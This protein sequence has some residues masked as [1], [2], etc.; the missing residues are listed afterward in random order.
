MLTKIDLY[1]EV[2]AIEPNSKVFFPLAK[3]L[4]GLDQPEEAV[5]VLKKG[6]AFHP[7]HLE[8]KFLL[9]ELLTRLER[10]DEAEEA[11]AGVGEMLAEYPSVWSL[12]AEKAV[13]AAKDPSLAL[14]FLAHYFRDG[15]L[16][17]ASVLEHGL[18]TLSPGAAPEPKTTPHSTDIADIA[19]VAEAG[20]ETEHASL[21]EIALEDYPLG[22]DEPE[23]L[24]HD[25]PA[26]EAYLEEPPLDDAGY[27]LE[28]ELAALE[29]ADSADAADLDDDADDA[30][31]VLRGADEVRSLAGILDDGPEEETAPDVDETPEVSAAQDLKEEEGGEGEEGGAD[32]AKA[33]SPTRAPETAS[34]QLPDM[35]V[36]TMTMAAMLAQQG[37]SKAA[38]AIYED[39]L[40]SAGSDEERRRIEKR[41]EELRNGSEVAAPSSQPAQK[42]KTGSKSKARLSGFL[43]ALAGRL[44]V[45]AR[46]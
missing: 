34:I 5:D 22:E 21:D 18:N 12:W 28:D 14:R 19:E 29:A 43:E 30:D 31:V 15:S 32:G 35:G 10:S 8:A 37:E 27:S 46:A 11:F 3:E 26:A 16:T 39:L 33:A 17:W 2:L 36:K 6:V 1:R 40:Q 24:M 44:E 20:E 4:A 23:R 25:Q 41:V 45:R 7:D 38:L 42:P 13:F 9:I